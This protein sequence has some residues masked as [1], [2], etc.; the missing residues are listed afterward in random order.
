MTK[1]YSKMKD[2]RNLACGIFWGAYIAAVVGV[3]AFLLSGC[4]TVKPPSGE[5][6]RET[7]IA[8]S[9]LAINTLSWT[10]AVTDTVFGVACTAQQFPENVCSVYDTSAVCAQV[11]INTARNALA[12]YERSGTV[13]NA[14]LLQ[15][16][17]QDL[18]PLIL[19]FDMIYKQPESVGGVA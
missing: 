5:I 7:M 9:E 13:L 12:N 16:S 10:K 18:A 4:A 3:A 15:A 17:I 1:I 2:R 8:R 11:A 19:K 6:D 14:D